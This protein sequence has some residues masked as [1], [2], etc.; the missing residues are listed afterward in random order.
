M[1]DVDY[2]KPITLG[3]QIWRD[4]ASGAMW[5]EKTEYHWSRKCGILDVWQ[6]YR[7]LR[8]VTGITLLL[9]FYSIKYT[10]YWKTF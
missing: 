2:R 1:L 8:S 10:M 5:K 6:P 3:V 7:P 4:I 9:L